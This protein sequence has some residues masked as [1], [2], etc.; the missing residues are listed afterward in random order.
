LSPWNQAYS[1]SKKM[2]WEQGAQPADGSTEGLLFDIDD[3]ATINPTWKCDVRYYDIYDTGQLIGGY[4]YTH[5]DGRSSAN[6]R[7][8]D[9]AS[10][11][12][13]TFDIPND[14]GFTTGGV[15][16]DAEVGVDFTV[17]D[18]RDNIFLRFTRDSTSLVAS[19]DDWAHVSDLRV[20][21]MRLGRDGQPALGPGAYNRDYVYAHEAVIDLWARFCPRI[22]VQNA[23]IDTGTFQFEQ[24]A[25]P[26]GIKPSGVLDE[27]MSAEG[28]FTWHV[29]E[30]Q[31]NGKFRAEWVERPT[32]VRYELD[33]YDG[34]R[35]SDGASDLVDR[36]FVIGK[37]ANGHEVGKIVYGSQPVLAAA[38]FSRSK[39]IDLGSDIWSSTAADRIGAQAIADSALRS[40]NASVTVARKVLD[41]YTGRYV[42][43]FHIKPGHLCRVRGVRPTPDTL[44][45]EGSSDGSSV[46]RIVSNTYSSESA[47]SSLELNSYTVTEAKA[48]AELIRARNR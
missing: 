2:K 41:L 48:I 18:H 29:W 7:I 8:Q 1:T 23:R 32:E 30:K 15:S 16:V 44:N 33:A 19:A 22:D 21:A 40:T 27:I 43:P 39:V 46:F 9:F 28:A 34:F 36:V 5:L 12:F 25:W 10:T 3:G 11:R 20:S 31:P 4:S 17:A 38:G 35:A 24:L 14:T 37:K 42:K 47:S 6:N 45:P 26:T 13:G